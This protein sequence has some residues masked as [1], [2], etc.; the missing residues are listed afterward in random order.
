[1]RKICRV[2]VCDKCQMVNGWTFETGIRKTFFDHSNQVCTNCG[3][4]LIV[5]TINV[6]RNRDGAP[7]GNDLQWVYLNRHMKVA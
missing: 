1:M 4:S 7:N 5:G 2:A 6:R 3:A